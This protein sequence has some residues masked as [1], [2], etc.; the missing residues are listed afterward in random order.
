MS[1]MLERAAAMIDGRQPIEMHGLIDAQASSELEEVAPDVGLVQA[2]SNV[3]VFR[4]TQGLVLF[5]VSH[6]LFAADARERMRRWSAAPVHTAVFTHGHADH[7]GGAAVFEA[8]GNPIRF[9][10]HEAVPARFQR[11]RRTRGY[12]A[13]INQ[14]QFGLPLPQFPSDWRAPDVTYRDTLELDIGGA[15]FELH[16]ARGETDD[17][18]WAFVPHCRAVV[19]GDLFLWQFPNAGNPQKAQRYAW[20]WAVALRDMLRRDPELLLPA[21]GPAVA[22]RDRIAR[23]LGDT[24][25]A[26][27]SLHEQVLVLMNEGARLDD[28]IHTVK[29]PAELAER[30]WLRATYD[31]PEFVVRNLWRLYGGWYDGNPATLKPA[32]ERALAAEIAGLCGGAQKLA[33]HAQALAARGD[34]RLACHFAEMA[35]L[36]EPD[37]NEHHAV[38]AEIY[39]ARRAQE[40]ALIARGIYAAAAEESRGRGR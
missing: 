15:R 10:A 31:D 26:L 22:G 24:A 33:A 11:Y 29:L 23:V 17:H 2:F 39:E 16:H 14:R 21:H 9:I 7:V 32:R 35:V 4:T 30:P 8:E 38:R 3:I 12:N 27:E 40:R 37:R 28:V 25:A 36:A 19:V 5:D 34:L 20:D 1:R 6:E 18:T 13:I